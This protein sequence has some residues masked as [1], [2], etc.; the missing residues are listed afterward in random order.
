MAAVS[1]A[2]AKPCA[3]IIKALL[4]QDMGHA[5]QE[6]DVSS[7]AAREEAVCNP[8]HQGL[9]CSGVQLMTNCCSVSYH[10]SGVHLHSISALC[11]E[12]L[13]I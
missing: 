7:V 10:T 13:T 12:L 3:L 4:L 8:A 1:H 5:G 11:N 9:G 2:A 6:E